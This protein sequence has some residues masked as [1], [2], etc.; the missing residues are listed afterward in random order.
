MQYQEN[1]FE[2][3]PDSQ[4]VMHTCENVNDIWLHNDFAP[5]GI[6]FFLIL[7]SDKSHLL[8]VCERS[9]SNF[10]KKH[11]KKDRIKNEFD[12]CEFSIIQSFIT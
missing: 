5:R 1:Q 11:S 8:L 4:W 3:V 7:L 9:N 12:W 10:S 2:N 6:T